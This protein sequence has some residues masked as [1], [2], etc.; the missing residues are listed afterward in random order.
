MTV[1]PPDGII[2]SFVYMLTDSDGA[3]SNAHLEIAFNHDERPDIQVVGSPLFLDEDMPDWA[4]QDGSPLRPG[5]G[6]A[7]REVADEPDR[8]RGFR[9]LYACGGCSPRR[10]TFDLTSWTPP[11]L[12]SGRGPVEWGLAPSDVLHA[13]RLPI[14]GLRMRGRHPGASVWAADVDT[15]SIDDGNL[16]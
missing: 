15:G 13:P 9:R 16:R 14:R 3:S 7:F 12:T 1:T 8:Y 2:V 4:N 5:G 6:G 11:T 10:L